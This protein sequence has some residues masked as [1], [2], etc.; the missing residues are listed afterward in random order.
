MNN[1]TGYS[2]LIQTELVWE[3]VTV[4]YVIMLSLHTATYVGT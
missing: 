1:G 3:W 2:W 4:Y